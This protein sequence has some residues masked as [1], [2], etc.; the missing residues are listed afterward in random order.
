MN[1]RHNRSPLTS[2]PRRHRARRP[3]PILHSYGVTPRKR[4][5]IFSTTATAARRQRRARTATTLAALLVL[6]AV[7]FG[8]LWSRPVALSLAVTPADAVIALAGSSP[9]TGTLTLPKVDPGAYRATISRTGFATRTVTLDARRLRGVR[10][11]VS[12]TPLPQRVSIAASPASARIVL[13]SGGKTLVQHAGSL[14]ATLPAGEITLHVT[15]DGRN[16]FTREIFLDA[17]LA[18]DVRLDPLGQVVHGLGLIECA[19]APKGVALNPAGTQAWTTILNGPPSIEI[20]EPR[21]GRRLGE[22]DIGKYGAVEV[23]FSQDGRFAYASQM[24]TAKVFEIDTATRKVT[25][26]FDTKS[27]W[28]KVVALSPDGKT[29]YAANWSGDDVSEIDVKSGTLRRRIPVA[30]TPRGLWPSADGKTLWVASFGVGHLE[31]VDLAS[32]DVTTVFK[33]GGALRHLVADEKRG[34]LFASDMAKDCVWVT[35]M[36]TGATRRFATVGHKPNTIDLSPDGRVLFVSNRG[37]NNSA[38]YYLPGPEWGSVLLLDAHTGAP[39]DGVVGGNQCTALDVTDDGKLLV[40]SDFLDDRLRVYEVPAFATLA[41]GGGG[42]A[43]TLAK[44]V[45]K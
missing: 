35:N 40:F 44:D 36:K 4:G 33:G 21:T 17:P 31:R 24:E 43:N 6:A 26:D 34:V 20:F 1:G 45:I 7:A 11:K 9:A 22:V 32:G 23:V 30:D 37:E 13:S 12:L 10:R 3:K 5:H 8:Y 25:R 28:T 29:L 19:G 27:A 16:D 2:S 39:L 14:A 38:S 42:R 18:L 41:K 15:A